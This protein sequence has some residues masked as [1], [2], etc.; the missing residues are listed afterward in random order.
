MLFEF[1]LLII[2]FK[3]E[4]KPIFTFFSFANLLFLAYKK[5]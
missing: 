4:I 5:I 2:N 1:L 3:F